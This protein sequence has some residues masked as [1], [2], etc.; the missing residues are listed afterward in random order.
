[1]AVKKPKPL[2]Y[3]ETGPPAPPPEQSTEGAGFGESPFVVPHQ[4]QRSRH[5]PHTDFLGIAEEKSE[6]WIK[7]GMDTDRA[8]VA[9]RVLS[10]YFYIMFGITDVPGDVGAMMAAEAGKDRLARGEAKDVAIGA[11]VNQG[12]P[13]LLLPPFGV[14]NSE[15]E[16][17]DGRS[18]RGFSWRNNGSGNNSNGRHAA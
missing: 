5:L 18:N 1:M 2:E 7:A 6:I 11:K 9:R 13:G 10:T 17:R 4:G 14:G 15:D 3:R 8:A 16:N 12:L